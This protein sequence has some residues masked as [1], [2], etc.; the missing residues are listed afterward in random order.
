MSALPKLNFTNNQVK[1]RKGVNKGEIWD[2]VR[3]KWL[4]LTPE[5]WVRQHVIS[6]FIEHLGYPPS[7]IA[8]EKKV[9]INGMAKRFD[10]LIY[11]N[12]TPLILIECKAP[13]VKI[14][15]DVFHQACRYN[16]SIHA[17]IIVVTNGLNHIIASIS[18]ETQKVNFIQ[19][20][21][22]KEH[23]S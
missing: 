20:F 12:S 22:A 21:P 2:I 11:H 15:E 1:L 23:W 10:A 8:V 9:T 6:H 16:T 7:T 4:I 18:T 5:E 19:D 14:T 3:K 13:E 17:Q